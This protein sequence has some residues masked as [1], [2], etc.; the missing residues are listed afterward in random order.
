MGVLKGTDQKEAATKAVSYLLGPEA[1]KYFA[2]TT[3]STRRRRH[4]DPGRPARTQGPQGLERRPHK[5]DSLGQTLALL[6]EV[7]LT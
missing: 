4:P 7:G 2:E 5:L 6:G 1:Q 3:S